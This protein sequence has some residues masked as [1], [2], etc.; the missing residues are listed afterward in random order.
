MRA[1]RLFVQPG[2]RD[3][4]RLVADAG[5]SDEFEP[6]VVPIDDHGPSVTAQAFVAG[7]LEDLIPEIRERRHGRV[8]VAQAGESD[9]VLD[10]ILEVWFG[11]GRR[12]RW[13]VSFGRDE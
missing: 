9:G 7:V 2:G 1:G 10:L 11:D 5:E 6:A 13:G 12:R 8:C 3:R 4:F